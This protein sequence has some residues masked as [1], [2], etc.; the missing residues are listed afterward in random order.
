M[1]EINGIIL[2]LQFRNYFLQQTINEIHKYFSSENTLAENL[3]RPYRL[4][5]I[6]ICLLLFNCGSSAKLTERGFKKLE[7]EEY[8]KANELFRKALEKNRNNSNAYYGLGKLAYEKK[9]YIDAI[10]LFDEA[11]NQGNE[12]AIKDRG[13]SYYSIA[14]KEYSNS[15]FKKSLISINK[16]LD[17]F[18]SLEIALELRAKILLENIK[19]DLTDNLPQKVISNYSLLVEQN[20]KFLIPIHEEIKNLEPRVRL[21]VAEY[22][23]SKSKDALALKDIDIVISSNTVYMNKYR[24]DALRLKSDVYNFRATREYDRENFS[25]ALENINKAISYSSSKN[26]L[27]NRG[28]INKELANIQFKKNNLREALKL[29]NSS[30]DEGRSSHKRR[31]YELRAQIFFAMAVAETTDINKQIELC[32]L[33]LKDDEYNSEIQAYIYNL[34]LSRV[35]D[36][37]DAKKYE[38]AK[39]IFKKAVT[40]DDSHIS[41]YELF[42]TSLNENKEEIF[43]DSAIAEIYAINL[44]Y[45]DAINLLSRHESIAYLYRPR[46]YFD[47]ARYYALNNETYSV[48]KILS[49]YFVKSSLHNYYLFFREKALTD[50]SFISLKNDNQFHK[51]LN[52]INRVKLTVNNI[53]NIPRRDSWSESDSYLQVSQNKRLLLTTPKAQDK[54]NVY[55]PEDLFH[56]VF[57]YDYDEPLV[58]LLTD[59][60]WDTDQVIRFEDYFNI[61]PSN[62]DVILNEK[63]DTKIN[64][65][66][67]D[68]SSCPYEY[69]THTELPPKSSFWSSFEDSRIRR[70]NIESINT[71]YNPEIRE[72]YGKVNQSYYFISGISSSLAPCFGSYAVAI[73]KKGFVTKQIFYWLIQ[74]VNDIDYQKFSF[75]AFL[76]YMLNKVGN[77]FLINANN[78]RIFCDCAYNSIKS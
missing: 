13:F 18:P 64:I 51:W 8:P 72:K 14:L 27:Y 11:I 73:S 1:E 16:S 69:S 54:A 45:K 46:F 9:E 35:A 67:E 23:L 42:Q 33:A 28:L 37:I 74:S 34:Y 4:V 25:L 31:Y 30:L 41:T 78:F 49:E 70:R 32:E 10:S 43:I 12:K 50:P 48:H 62:Y 2:P 68:C 17:D 20:D 7:K 22:N 61:H 36:L 38:K 5:I 3:K 29:I 52:G 24:K 57:D 26:L 40:I 21:L 71:V 58:F 53:L 77:N 39:D 63:T 47:L 59:S 6:S 76:E 44:R 75:E 55:W 60:D 65:D 66:F 15:H 19:I 56:V